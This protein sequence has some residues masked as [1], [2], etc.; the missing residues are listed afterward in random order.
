MCWTFESCFAQD[1]CHVLS[2][3]WHLSTKHLIPFID[4]GGEGE[5]CSQLRFLTAPRLTFDL[6]VS[7]RRRQNAYILMMGNSHES[8]VE[9]QTTYFLLCA[10][11][12]VLTHVSCIRQ[13][14]RPQC[15]QQFVAYKD[16]SRGTLFRPSHE[17]KITFFGSPLSGSDVQV[18]VARQTDEELLFLVNIICPDVNHLISGFI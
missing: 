4:W 13:L 15:A 14:V 17:L 1:A 2:D 8:P 6:V 16:W 3:V 12:Y 11:R 18:A 9:D 7:G 5:S 10:L